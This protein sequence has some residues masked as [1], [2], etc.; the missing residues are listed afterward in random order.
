MNT[1]V[2][3]YSMDGNTRLV[4][5]KIAEKTGA[6]LVEAEPIKSYPDKGGK[7]FIC[8][9]FSAVTG[10]KPKLKPYKFNAEEYDSIVIGSPVWA[11]CF[12]PPIRSFLSVNREKLNGKEIAVYFCCSGGEAESAIQRLKE[13]IGIDA[14][15]AEMVLVDPAKNGLD[16]E[17]VNSF[18]SKIL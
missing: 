9:G 5:E 11:G 16:E 4:A 3:Y 13:Y 10:R 17:T 7:K 1:A 2:I 14:F 8:G 18:C 15:S 6:D 12:A